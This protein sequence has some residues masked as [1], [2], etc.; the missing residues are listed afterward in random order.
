MIGS[1]T[2]A[3]CHDKC[4]GQRIVIGVLWRVTGWGENKSVTGG[5][6]NKTNGRKSVMKAWF[7]GL[8]KFMTYSWAWECNY[9][10]NHQPAH[11]WVTPN[12]ICLLVG[13]IRVLKLSFSGR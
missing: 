8:L 13:G 3:Q 12:L 11:E 5:H 6:G 1:V 10:I 7:Q 4:R 2:E 9:K